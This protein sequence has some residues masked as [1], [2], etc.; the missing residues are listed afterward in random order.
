MSTTQ[1]IAT[2]IKGISTQ[3]VYAFFLVLGRISPLFLVAPA[4]SSQMLIPRV[5]SVIAVALAIGLT[6]IADHGQT[7]PTGVL[8][9]FGLLIENFLVGFALAYTLSCVF[10]SV[11]A[12]GVFADAFSGFSIGQ[13]V[14]PIN[15]NPGGSLTNL[16]SVFG[17]VIFLIIGGDAWTLRG[18]TATMRA[19]PIGD[20]VNLKP[21]AYQAESAFASVFIGAVEI[22]APLMLALIVSDIAFGMVAK[23]VPQLNVFSVG[24]PMKVGVALLVV[25][26]S[27]PFLATWMTGQ[28]TGT[29]TS[30]LQALKIA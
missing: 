25:A 30:A 12:A 13:T 7:L 10:A 16:Y 3:H 15:G 17:L 24:I 2:L 8:E 5:R 27:L 23:V 20:A 14:D 21:L 19:V 26:A 29:V 28:L 11:Q 18:I 9:L 22:A 1:T 6:G 4:F